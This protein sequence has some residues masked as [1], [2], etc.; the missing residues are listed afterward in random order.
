MSRQYVFVIIT[1]T[2]LF[3]TLQNNNQVSLQ[4]YSKP[5]QVM[6]DTLT[7]NNKLY[8]TERLGC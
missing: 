1:P 2:L 6:S 5:V 4:E 3:I 8:L 7:F